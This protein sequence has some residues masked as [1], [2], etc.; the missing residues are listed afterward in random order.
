MSP[1]VVLRMTSTTNK[2]MIV[3]PRAVKAV[4]V[5]KAPPFPYSPLHRSGLDAYNG[6]GQMDETVKLCNIIQYFYWRLILNVPESCP[7]LAILCESNAVNM[8]FRI[9]NDKCQLLA[10]IK[11]LE[12][13]ALAKQYINVYGNTAK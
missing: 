5:G 1:C 12:E 3:I 8:K 6:L 9:W 13:G 7:R 2:R 11:C 10:R 4:T